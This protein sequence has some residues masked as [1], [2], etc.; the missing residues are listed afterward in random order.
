[1][2]YSSKKNWNGNILYI[3]YDIEVFNFFKKKLE[4]VDNLLFGTEVAD[5]TECWKWF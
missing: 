2:K 4:A 1:M 3:V 5:E